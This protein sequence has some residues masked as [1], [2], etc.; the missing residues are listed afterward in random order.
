MYVQ[1]FQHMYV[2]YLATSNEIPEVGGINRS[3]G[4]NLAVEWF[5][6]DGKWQ[7]KKITSWILVREMLSNSKFLKWW[8]HKFCQSWT[9]KNHFEWRNR[10][11]YWPKIVWRCLR[12]LPVFTLMHL[13]RK[14]LTSRVTLIN[15]CKHNLLIHFI[16]IKNVLEEKSQAKMYNSPIE[17]WVI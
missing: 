14:P 5:V 4:A 10:T 15:I 1:K 7:I 2:Q 16:L 9:D 13:W 8:W 11:C 17:W 3:S 12:L 6:R